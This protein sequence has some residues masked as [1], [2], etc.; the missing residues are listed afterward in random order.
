MPGP[1]PGRSFEEQGRAQ[2]SAPDPHKVQ[3]FASLAGAQAASSAAGAPPQPAVQPQMPQPAVQ[4]P[5]SPPPEEREELKKDISDEEFDRSVLRDLLPSTDGDDEQAR[6]ARILNND[7][8]R[9]RIE[10]NLKPIRAED[11]TD[12]LEY[13]QEV[14][15]G[16]QTFLFRSPSQGE[17]EEVLRIFGNEEGTGFYLSIKISVMLTTVGIVSVNNFTLPSHLNEQGLFNH[18]LFTRKYAALSKF[19]HNVVEDARLQFA[20]FDERVSKFIGSGAL[21]NG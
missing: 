12:H 4:P 18:E 1:M 2:A 9:K 8:R 19:P 16:A 15:T 13:R 3:E 17:M 7:A 21:G 11:L 10:D 5:Q 20:W 14:P 6:R